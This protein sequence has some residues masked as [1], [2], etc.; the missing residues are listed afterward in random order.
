VR[1]R[2]LAVESSQSESEDRVCDRDVPCARSLSD[3]CS[4][5]ARHGTAVNNT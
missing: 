1:S 5:N 2:H 4:G 3:A